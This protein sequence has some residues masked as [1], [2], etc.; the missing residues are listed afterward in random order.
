MKA[1]GI[2]TTLLIMIMSTLLRQPPARA[3]RGPRGT[4]DPH[5]RGDVPGWVMITLMSAVLVAALLA[6]AVPALEGLFNQAMDKVG[7]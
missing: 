2:R 7:Q 4:G 1:I 5:E 6:L 3:E